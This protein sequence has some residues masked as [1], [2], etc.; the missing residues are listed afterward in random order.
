MDSITQKLDALQQ[1]ANQ[2]A[3]Q[4]SNLR[5]QIAPLESLQLQ[6]MEIQK[7][8]HQVF[9]ALTALREVA[10]TEAETEQAATGVE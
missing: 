3:I 4:E 2:L 5:D 9:G 10:A 7:V 1:R 8:K 6:L